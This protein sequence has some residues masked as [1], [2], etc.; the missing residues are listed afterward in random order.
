MN[1]HTTVLFVGPVRT[2]SGYGARSRDICRSLIDLGYDLYV[3]PTGWGNTPA[4][5]D[6]SGLEGEN[7]DKIEQCI[8]KEIK[9]QPELFIQCTIPNEFRPAGKF[10][11]GITA[12]IETDTCRIEWIEGCNRMDMVVTSSEHSKRVFEN[13]TYEKRDKRTNQVVETIKCNTPIEVMFEG[14]DT[15][16]YNDTPSTSQI[17]DMLNDIDEDY[18]FLFV[19]HWLQGDIGHDRK[20]VGALIDT[21]INT[22]TSTNSDRKPALLLKTSLA[23]FSKIE[24]NKITDR[25]SELITNKQR[26][27]SNYIL[28]KVYLINGDLSDGGMNALY[29]HT[30]I[31]AMVSFTK[32]EGFGRPLLEFT[33]TGKPVIASNW[34]GQ[35]D[36]LNEKYS[37]LLAGSLGPVHQSA[38]ND[39]I[40]KDSKWF[41]VN[42]TEA[43]KVLVDCFENYDSYHTKGLKQKKYTLDKFKL[44][45]MTSVLESLLAKAKFSVKLHDWHSHQNSPKKMNID[46]SK[47]K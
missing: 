2:R 8:N 47:I 12:G 43:S 3:I 34:S 42:Y 41:T 44:S 24:R 17:S 4:P 29:N 28:P 22:F 10:N 37:T 20:D 39:W 13:M 40:M 33:A 9:S 35:V 27:D 31:K 45:D 36:F 30:K 11:I 5:I 25:I 21:F 6:T 38:V 23:G 1:S 18:L 7:M 32:G 16:I 26:Q 15:S 14:I 46:T 19:G